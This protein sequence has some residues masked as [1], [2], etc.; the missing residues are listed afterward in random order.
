MLLLEPLRPSSHTPGWPAPLAYAAT[1]S[2]LLETQTPL[3]SLRRPPA[4]RVATLAPGTTLSCCARLHVLVHIPGDIGGAHGGGG[5]DGNG[6]ELG[7]NGGAA[8][9]RSEAPPVFAPVFLPAL[10]EE[11]G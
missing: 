7:G 5:D 10:D 4:G 3:C 8:G 9:R 2:W 11:E 1:S 6:G